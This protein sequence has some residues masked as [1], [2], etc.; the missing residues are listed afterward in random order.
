MRQR[1]LIS[2][3]HVLA[4]GLRHV[5]CVADAPAAVRTLRTRRASHAR[6][7]LIST[8]HVLAL[9]LAMQVQAAQPD[10]RP[11]RDWAVD[12]TVP[13]ENLPPV[14]RSLFDFLV[15]RGEGGRYI[16]DVPFPITALMKKLEAE[17]QRDRPDALPVKSVLIPLGR[18]LQRTSAAPDFFAFPR[19][20][21]APD[22]EPRRSPTHAGML[23]KDRV[24]VGFQ[25]K[26]ELIEVISYNEA[27]GRFEFQVVKDYRA[28]ATPKVFYA[29]RA[30]CTSCHQ[31][32]A[33]IFSRQL[34]DETNANRAVS[35]LL[36]RQKRSFYGVDPQRGVD[37]P[38]GLDN[39]SD[40]A[41][42]FAAY[43]LLWREGCEVRQEAERSLRCRAGLYTAAL[44][45][46]LSGRQ[47]FDRDSLG[48]RASVV[49]VMARSARE[50]WPNGLRIPNADLPNRDPL[51]SVLARAYSHGGE[52]APTLADRVNVEAVFDPLVARSASDIWQVSHP[53]TLH[54]LV[55]GLS[56][57]L[58]ESDALRLSAEL[59]RVAASAKVTRATYEAECELRRTARSATAYRVDFT[60]VPLADRA[61]TATLHGRVYVENAK[62]VHGAIERLL[63]RDEAQPDS[64][65]RDVDISSG[66]IASRGAAWQATLPL[67]R[68]G[69]QARRG[70]GN[71]VEMLRIDSERFAQTREDTV[72]GRATVIVTHDF[73]PVHTAIQS[74]VR[75]SADGRSDVFANKPFRRASLMPTL[76]E[77]MGMKPLGWCCVN[78]AGMPPP[79]M[80]GH[81]S[82]A[83]AR[84]DADA[85]PIDHQPFYRY[86]ATCH[87]SSDRSPPNFLQ[88][89]AS[90]VAANLAHCAQRL[91]VRL[92]MWHLPPERRSKTAM[93][94]QYALYGFHTSPEAWRD[95]GELTALRAHIERLLQAEHGKAPRPEELLSRGYENL[96]PCLPEAS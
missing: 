68:G 95:S 37:L 14:G 52:A 35:T 81:T 17:L 79:A 7:I 64:E 56:E 70:D 53:A 28:G 69:A 76:F 8:I 90:A 80:E 72:D 78:D 24:Y 10:S 48:F 67:A 16:Y 39:A 75:E 85:K 73:E 60:C 74:I 45:Y 33:P 15:V 62:R 34:W 18:S 21:F 58:A 59:S 51:A 50:N 29:N 87:Q 65:L 92:A 57:F 94:P 27:A 13:G 44:Q 12:P 4:L 93:P 49:A 5:G 42:L 96:R 19:L 32:A 84:A 91:H 11:G 83:T 26:A 22:A 88:G 47:Q 36:T 20:V 25:E 40:R 41:N 55:A 77:R 86:C 1:I 54:R 31:N 89:S 9:S 43:Q 38:Y 6:C 23:L 46:L 3:I 61:R 71:A 2:A 63:M 82:A 30:I 66:R